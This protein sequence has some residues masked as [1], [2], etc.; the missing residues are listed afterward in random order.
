MLTPRDLAY[1]YDRWLAARWR[2]EEDEARRFGDWIES[3]WCRT[4]PL[5][6]ERGPD[7][8]SVL[9]GAGRGIRWYADGNVVRGYV[10]GR[11]LG[12]YLIPARTVPPAEVLRLA[13]GADPIPD[14]AAAAVGAGAW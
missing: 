14:V 11:P 4:A 12:C 13:F 9:G 2:G 3:F 1:A 6:P 8:V 7:A 5:E 10:V